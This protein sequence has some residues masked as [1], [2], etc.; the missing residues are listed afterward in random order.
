MSPPLGGLGCGLMLSS[1]DASSPPAD[2]VVAWDA[3]YDTDGGHYTTSSGH[4][5]QWT[6]QSGN[7]R[8]LTPDIAADGPVDDASTPNATTAFRFDGTSGYLQGS[9]ASN[10]IAAGAATIF[11]VLKVHAAPTNNA[12]G[13]DNRS[14]VTD[15]QAGGA[16]FELAVKNSTHIYFGNYD[17]SDDQAD[18]TIDG[19]WHVVEMRHESGNIYIRIDG[20]TEATVA[21]GNTS[22]LTGLFTVAYNAF[23]NTYAQVDMAALRCKKTALDLTTRDAV[24]AFLKYKYGIA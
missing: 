11:A 4:V 18:T 7:A 24:V 10:F 17:G 12:D 3:A 5:D 1:F 14:I 15:G 8:H 19:A 16:F 23:N 6:D 20:V 22:D 13:W 21:S 2:P 9:A